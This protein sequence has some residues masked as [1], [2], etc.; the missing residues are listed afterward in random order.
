MKT[1]CKVRSIKFNFKASQIVNFEAIKDL[2]LNGLLNSTVTVRTDKNISRKR[3]DG[4]CVSIV[5][6]AEDKIYR[7]SLFKRRCLDDSTP[8]P[9]RI[10]KPVAWRERHFD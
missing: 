6:E 5:T 8:Y 9:L 3:G 7:V 4:A 2:A 10:N 1:V